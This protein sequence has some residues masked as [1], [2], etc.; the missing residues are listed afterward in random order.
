[1]AEIEAG[2]QLL[3]ASR[4]AT[5]WISVHK[6]CLFTVCPQRIHPKFSGFPSSSPQART[7]KVRP[8][9]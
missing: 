1:M 2:T 5:L 3:G 7:F 9:S 8:R 4:D 6:H